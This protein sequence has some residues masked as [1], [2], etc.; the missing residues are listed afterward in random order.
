MREQ[1]I[2]ARTT[3]VENLYEEL[4]GPGSGECMGPD[5]KPCSLPDKEHEVITDLPERRYYVGVLYPQRNQMNQDNDS[6]REETA[7]PEIEITDITEDE[8]SSNERGMPS[9][10]PDISDESIDEVIALSTQD[11]P[12]SI[13]ISFSSDRD[14]D[15]VNVEF[16]FATYHNTLPK[17]CLVPYKRTELSDSIIAAPPFEQ[18]VYV[19]D[20]FLLLKQPL[21]S[22]EVTKNWKE[23]YKEATELRSALY[24]LSAQCKKDT[25]F[26]REPH[27][28]TITLPTDGTR[29]SK[30]D[31][32]P[33]ANACAI[34]NKAGNSRWTI[35][36]MLFNSTVGPFCGTNSLF[37]PSIIINSE[38]N[39]HFAILPYIDQANKSS[40]VEE[41]SLALLYRNKTRYASGHGVA[42]KWDVSVDSFCVQTDLMPSSEI[43]QMDFDYA[44]SRGVSKKALSVKFLSDLSNASPAERRA[45][46]KELVDAYEMWITELR[47]NSVSQEF[48]T[49]S[50]KH[51]A[52]CQT[53]ADR[54]K[55]GL[56]CLET[57][58]LAMKAFE[59]ANRAMFMQMIHRKQVGSVLEDEDSSTVPY[60]ELNYGEIDRD[61]SS[62]VWRPFQAAFLLM[63]IKGLITK[64]GETDNSLDRD[65][66]DIIWFPTGGGKTEAYLAVTAFTIFYRRMKYPTEADGTAIL[67]RYTLRLLTSQ[68][69]AR[70]STLICACEQIRKELKKTDKANK[71]GWIEPIT[72]GL[73][74]GGDHTPNKT[75]SSNQYDDK[76]A[77]FYWKKLTDSSKG[78]NDLTYRNETYNRFQ[79]LACPWCGASLVPSEKSSSREKWGYRMSGPHFEL[80]CVR[81]RCPF[82]KKLPIQ[83]VDDEL[84]QAPPTLL[85]ATVDKFAMM[86]WNEKIGSFFAVN[87]KNRAPELIIQDELHLISGPLGSIVGLY[88]S[89]IDSLCSAKGVKPKII[90]STATIRRAEEQCRYLYNRPVQQFPPS[91]L[92]SSDSFFAKEADSSSKPG[93]LYVG[94]FPSGK[95]KA[96]LETR[97]MST[98]LQRV[99]ML[100]MPDNIKDK[101]WTLVG[102]FNNL[103]D[104]GKCS[105]LVDDDIKDFMKRMCRRI[106]SDSQVRPISIASELT[107]RVSTTTLVKRLKTLEKVEYSKENQENQQYA[108]NVLLATNMISVGV[109][110]DRLNLMTVVGQPKL[111]SEYIQATSR[112]GRKFPGLVFTLYDATKSRDR[113]HYEQFHAYH[114]SFYRYVEPTSVTPFSKPALDRALHSVLISLV[115]NVDNQ[116]AKEVDAKNLRSDAEVVGTVKAQFLQRIKGIYANRDGETQADIQSIEQQ[117]DSFFKEWT[118]FAENLPSEDKLLYGLNCILRLPGA[119]EHVLLKPYGKWIPN[120]D[121]A[122]ETLTSMRN[123][124]QSISGRLV[125]WEEECHEEN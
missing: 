60:N 39:S 44:F 86:P 18:Y 20:G 29:I 22:F 67:M 12:S 7:I 4:V 64:S 73:W 21:A 112:V 26:K 87:T 79:V 77:E 6:S 9:T 27:K 3:L 82:E 109:D 45:A 103:R 30:V 34:K 42:A 57:D 54:M 56:S 69:F 24:K 70:A 92:D 53:A 115:R 99:H 47:N 10:T 117:I 49:V 58:P 40:D 85:F 52:L 65:I 38:N 105:G 89:A 33:F 123:V 25:G 68:Q 114:E 61:Y 93:R 11:R 125:I 36:I 113:S 94:I 55:A 81:P 122:H 23:A 104:L 62:F 76:S 98:L 121:I 100:D 17:D 90:A 75:K 118:D 13:G 110:V 96:M 101:Y 78:R 15:Q 50:D 74:I 51:I 95:T 2:H 111:T 8:N 43:P 19:K 31:N 108:I 14:I 5:G 71:N 63:S 1:C 106:S 41:K 116:L 119:N 37:Q 66:V 28:I 120:N 59:L 91:G 32:V 107:S 16:K 88:E 97:V 35:T 48:R 83:V 102:Y 46:V 72:I 124:D 84:Y 80:Q